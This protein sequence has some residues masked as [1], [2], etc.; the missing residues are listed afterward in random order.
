MINRFDRRRF[1]LASGGAAGMSLVPAALRADEA[2]PAATPHASGHAHEH[3]HGHEHGHEEEGP[4]YLAVG[5]TDAG[6]LGV[7]AVPGMELVGTL[8]D[9]SVSAHAGF[10][11]LADGSVLFMDEAGSRLVRVNLANG[12]PEIT[13]EAPIT[14]HVAHIAI[15][16]DHA[17]YCAVGTSGEDEYQL[18]LVNLETWEVTSLQIPDAAEVGLM[19]THHHLFHRNSNLSQLE[20]YGISDLLEG[21]VAPLS[22]LPIGTFGHGEAVNPGTGELYMATDDGVD[23]A[24]WDDIALSFGQT[25]AWPDAE[26]PARGFFTRLAFDQSHL[27]TYT[28]DRSADETAWET[29]ENTSVI[30][31]VATGDATTADLG[32]GYTFRFALAQHSALFYLLGGNGDEAV[33]IDLDPESTSFG[34]VAARISLDPMTG[35]AEV[36]SPFYEVGQYRSVAITP[37]GHYGYVT[38][39]GDGV[40]VELDLAHEEVTQSIDHATDL[41]GGGVMVVFGPGAP[42]VD[43]IGR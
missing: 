9:V 3:E 5:D 26:P 33:L 41:N 40:I 17:H 23:I 28:S 2:S 37:D 6:T 8:Q 7:Y 42:F 21:T 20:A 39:G 43:T 16:S 27:V 10:L 14:G 25:W 31:D 1:V 36:G 29:W 22:T 4:I 19:M 34:E 11:P 24:Y 32:D 12:V 15:D 13:G 38:Q 18:H 35:A 30:Y